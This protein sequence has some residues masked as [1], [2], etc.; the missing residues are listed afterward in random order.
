MNRLGF[1]VIPITAAGSF[2]EFGKLLRLVDTF[3]HSVHPVRV[4]ES[5]K[6]DRSEMV[7]ANAGI[8]ARYG[9]LRSSFY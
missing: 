3:G 5:F 8:L 7:D 1:T 4:V 2:W 6:L 9:D